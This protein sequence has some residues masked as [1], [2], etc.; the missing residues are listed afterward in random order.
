MFEAHDTWFITCRT[1]QARKLM[2]PSSP[3]VREVC[4]GVLAK[5][6]SVSGVRLH[7]YVFLSNHLH[8]I[9][10]ARGQRIAAFMKYL[11]GN[12]SK[13]LGPLCEP[14]WWGGFWERRYSAIPILDEAALEDRLRYVIAHGVKE[15]LVAHASDWEGL[16]CVQQLEDEKPR[17]FRWYNWT[18]RWNSRRQKGEAVEPAV[19]RYDDE[20]SEKVSL[21]LEPLPHWASEDAPKRQRRMR[22]L[23]AEVERAVAPRGQPLGVEAIRSQSTEPCWRRKRTPRPLCHASDAGARAHYRALYRAFCE[24]FRS[25]ARRWLAGDRTPIFPPGSFRPHVYE[26]R[27]IRIV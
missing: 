4:G 23:V 17:V 9:V 6:V 1:F 11:L 10:H 12:L 2:A 20:A 22:A 13:K 26:I 15:G 24:E 8:L 25:A 14:H 18:K 16:H 19:S 7:A 5:A 27:E 3:L 21:E